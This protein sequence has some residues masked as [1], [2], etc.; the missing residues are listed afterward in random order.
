MAPISREDV[1]H[2]ARLARLDVT[3]EE[4]D[5]FAGQ[6]AGVLEHAADLAVLDTAGVAP[7]AHPFPLVN[8]LRDD[9]VAAS[10]DRDEVLAM[11][12]AAEDGRFRV[13]RILGEAP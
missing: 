7:T 11:A 5:R 9:V 6:L 1:A 12:P 4:L 10:L 3:E 13:P 2:V 8:V